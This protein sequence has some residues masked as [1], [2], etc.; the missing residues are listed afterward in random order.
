M[1][2]KGLA[3]VAAI[4]VLVAVSLLFVGAAKDKKISRLQ[5]DVKL[6]RESQAGTADTVITPAGDTVVRWFRDSAAT[7][8]V[9][10]WRKRAASN[11]NAWQRVTQQRDSVAEVVSW[12]RDSVARAQAESVFG[13]VDW[14]V[15]GAKYSYTAIR[16][17][18]GAVRAGRG[19]V[20]RRYSV[21]GTKTAVFVDQPRPCLGLQWE[22]V[23]G[24]SLWTPADS[25]APKWYPRVGLRA[26]SNGWLVYHLGVVYTG[27]K[28]PTLTTG[29]T[30]EWRL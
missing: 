26:V 18:D 27:L 12:L 6:L 15:S 14:R 10:E 22:F 11:L 8:A 17:S 21:T 7:Q 20:G 5:A 1:K 25:F 16:P 4:A 30:A 19:R 2:T 9:F 23:A 29:I 3:A 13:V 24:V 28:M